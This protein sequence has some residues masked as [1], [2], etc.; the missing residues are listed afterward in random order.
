M[1][2]VIKGMEKEILQPCL[3]SKAVSVSRGAVRDIKVV[4][5]GKRM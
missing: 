3:H 4:K 2:A 5:V 1:S